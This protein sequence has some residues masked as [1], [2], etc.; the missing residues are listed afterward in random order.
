[1]I[2]G[3]LSDGGHDP[4]RTQVHEVERGTLVCLQDESGV[5]REIEPP[6]R[7]DPED[8][9]HASLSE[10]DEDE[11]A[12]RDCGVTESRDSPAESRAGDTESK[13]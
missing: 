9:L 6:E 2:E 10:G 3:K 5:F 13:H 11:S 1:M 4:L 8:S 7:D 12:G